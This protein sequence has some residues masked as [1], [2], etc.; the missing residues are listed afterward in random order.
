MGIIYK[1]CCKKT[2]M[3]K[4]GR[5]CPMENSVGDV[6]LIQRDGSIQI[7]HHHIYEYKKG[8]RNLILHTLESNLMFYAE[9]KLQ[10]IGISYHIHPVDEQKSNIFFG[11]SECVEAVRNIGKKSL[12]EFSPE[13]DFILGIMLGYDRLKQAKRYNERKRSYI[14]EM[15][16]TS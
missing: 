11:D 1:G 13:E 6:F 7:F 15:E 2:E 9:R 14:Q 12:T 4:P 16:E 8:V 3:E 5:D 10:R